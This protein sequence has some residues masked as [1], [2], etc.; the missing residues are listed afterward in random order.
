MRLSQEL[1]ME[2][3]AHLALYSLTLETG[4]KYHDLD[5]SILPFLEKRW[6]D[7]EPSDKVSSKKFFTYTHYFFLMIDFVIHHR[8][9]Q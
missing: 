4:K 7:F 2:D 8:Y 6:K 5:K 3:I 9:C 1:T